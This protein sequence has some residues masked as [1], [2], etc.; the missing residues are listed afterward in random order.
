MKEGRM[1]GWRPEGN[2]HCVLVSVFHWVV[3]VMCDA[4]LS[5]TWRV[6]RGKWSSLF[7]IMWHSREKRAPQTLVACRG[8]SFFAK[9]P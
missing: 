1:L 4:K 9:Q 5:M 3:P 8:I 6:L 2:G 7:V